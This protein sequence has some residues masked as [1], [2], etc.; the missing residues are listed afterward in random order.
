MYIVVSRQIGNVKP[1]ATLNLRLVDIL[2][3]VWQIG[4]TNELRVPQGSVL[5]PL[6]YT[7]YHRFLK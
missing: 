4:D 6:L 2:S 5:G 1:V 3:A 7:L